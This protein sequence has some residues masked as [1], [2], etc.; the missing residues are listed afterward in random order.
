MK[1]LAET[2]IATTRNTIAMLEQQHLVAKYGLSLPSIPVSAVA[3]KSQVTAGTAALSRQSPSAPPEIHR[4]M[5]DCL[6]IDTF[7]SSILSSNEVFVELAWKV[8]VKNACD[9][10][11]ALRVTF[12]IYDKDEFELDSDIEDITVP[13]TGIGKAR[14]KMLVSP[15]GKARRMA[16]QGA[17]LSI[18]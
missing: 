8:D 13:P 2:A 18:R 3:D 12:T 10:L 7:D 6:E 16:R 15:P 1:A 4:K 5:S 11:F 14:G 17:K 9:H